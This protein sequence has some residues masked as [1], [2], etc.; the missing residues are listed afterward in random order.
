MTDFAVVNARRG[1]GMARYLLSKM[2]HAAAQLGIITM[3]PSP[4]PFNGDERRF[5]KK[6]VLLRR[7]TCK[8]HKHCGAHRKHECMV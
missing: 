5:F 2:E 3:S 6:R 8:Q 7:N 4:S 1:G